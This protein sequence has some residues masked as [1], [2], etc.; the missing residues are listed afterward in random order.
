MAVVTPRMVQVASPRTGAHRLPILGAAVTALLIG[1]MTPAEG[2]QWSRAYIRALP[3]SAFASVEVRSD[4][5]KVRH[6]PHHDHAGH[7]DPSHLRSALSRIH[8]VKWLDPAEKA[9]ALQHLQE[10][11]RELRQSRPTP[12]VPH[13]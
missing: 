12:G 13:K 7:V 6:L 4:G 2:A 8:Q 11:L 10:H 9:R 3:D 5:T 1:L